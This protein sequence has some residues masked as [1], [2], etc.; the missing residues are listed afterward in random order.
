MNLIA[1]NAKNKEFLISNRALD[2]IIRLICQTEE[3]YVDEN[4]KRHVEKIQESAIGILCHLCVNHSQTEYVLQ[5][6]PKSPLHFI[7]LGKLMQS[8]PAILKQTLIVSLLK[9]FNF[10]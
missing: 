4:L 8:R 5:T 1:N 9:K 7:L 10:F 6:I 3:Y 2:A